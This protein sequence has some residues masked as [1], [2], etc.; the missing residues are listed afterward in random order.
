MCG[1]CSLHGLE[2]E[3]E[4]VIWTAKVRGGSGEDLDGEE[5][6]NEESC[7]EIHDEDCLQCLCCDEVVLWKMSSRG[8]EFG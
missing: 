2:R 6:H 1:Y 8:A 5:G 3:W 4:T 7:D